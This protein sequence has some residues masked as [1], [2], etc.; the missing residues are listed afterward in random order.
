MFNIPDIFYKFPYTY[1]PYI[2][3]VLGCTIGQQS[4]IKFNVVI[5]FWFSF[6]IIQM[7]M[8]AYLSWYL[9]NQ[10]IK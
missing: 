10:I 7:L 3:F 5:V 2:L 4:K 1:V 9:N 6:S 8:F